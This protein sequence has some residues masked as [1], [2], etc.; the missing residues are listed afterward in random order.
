LGI[1]TGILKDFALN[2]GYG[3]RRVWTEKGMDREGYGQR[4]VWTEKGKERARLGDFVDPP[5]L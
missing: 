5:S 4:R 2:G 3:Q 1:L